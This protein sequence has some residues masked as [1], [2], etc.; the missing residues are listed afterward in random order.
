M[1]KDL[2]E[3]AER[4]RD[5]LK[6]RGW[7]GFHT[8]KSLS[9]AIAIEAAELMEIFQWHDNLSAEEYENSTRVDNQVE[10]ELADILI[11]SLTLAADFNIDISDAVEA[12]L[13]EN[14]DRFAEEEAGEML[15]EIERWLR[16]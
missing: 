10:E 15:D 3:A 12:K 16:D 2:E 6:T 4:H 9:M 8:P 14:E 11:Y 1:V 5:F 13:D 7:E